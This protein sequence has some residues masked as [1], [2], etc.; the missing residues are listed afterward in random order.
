MSDPGDT[1][2]GTPTPELED[3][4]ETF[5]DPLPAPRLS[6]PVRF[7]NPQIPE[8]ER[9][10]A[11]ISGDNLFINQTNEIIEFNETLLQN[12][13]QTLAAV[14]S[15]LVHTNHTL[16]TNILDQTIT[17][18]DDG[19]LLQPNNLETI[20]SRQTENP[21]TNT[22]TPNNPPELLSQS[23]KSV[24]TIGLEAALKLLPFTFSGENQEDLKLFLETCEFAIMCANEKAKQR[25]LQ[26]IIIR[27]TGKARAAVKFRSIQSWT[28]LKDTLK[29]SLEPQRTTP[30]LYLELYSIKQKGD[31]DVM[32]YSSRIE[33]LQTLILEQ[34]TNG[35]S[36]EVATAL[37]DSLKAQTIQVFIEGLGKLKDFIKARNPPTLDKAI[38]AARE[39]ERVRKSHDESKRFY[40]PS[41]K[42]NHG[43]TLTKKPS[44][45][46]FH[47]GKMGHW[48]KDCRSL[49]VKPNNGQ[50]PQNA[51]K[52]IVNT[53]TC[54]YCKKPGHTK[55]ECR[56]LKYV[57]SKRSAE[58]PA[59][60]SQ[61]SKNSR[62]S[63]AD[64]G[65][66]AGS[67]KTAAISFTET[68]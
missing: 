19:S 10:V 11:E 50:T 30:H 4:E 39:E 15:V 42:Q 48:A 65:R 13:N 43:K 16:H 36:A 20:N 6:L 29:T 40:E 31:E 12:V 47:C 2:S 57:N 37:E 25:L 59:T 60:T 51:Q 68:S 61:N 45:P 62:Q 21:V 1:N 58:S 23:G 27:L 7:A 24:D 44:T 63:S 3:R 26:G 8:S 52:A 9:P 54:R 33:A 38:Q 5:E 22:S 55:E 17:M 41:A 49:Q 53:I 67:L 14:D 66:P 18:A 28:E 34:E 56:K 64:G 46:C 35:K 32:T